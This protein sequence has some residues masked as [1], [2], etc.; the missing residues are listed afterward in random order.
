MT[1]TLSD[2]IARLF[3]AL[4]VT[5]GI[6]ASTIALPRAALAEDTQLD[7]MRAR[8]AAFVT[9]R[10]EKLGG[11]RI[12]YRVDVDDLRAS[13]VTEL[14]DEIYNT[15]RADK[16]AFAGLAIRVGGVE[17]RIADPKSREQLVRKL[18]SAARLP[19]NSTSSS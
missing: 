14:R 19:K 12:V 17:L 18:A 5:S 10:M 7:K 16:T 15:L 6:M 11:S 4:A 13:A 8:I 3:V 1:A 9:E 2:R